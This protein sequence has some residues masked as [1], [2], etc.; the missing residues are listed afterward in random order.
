MMDMLHVNTTHVLEDL[1]PPP[2][3]IRYFGLF[4]MST[5]ILQHILFNEI[6]LKLK[7]SIP[8]CII[9]TRVKE[10]GGVKIK[11]FRSRS[12]E[13]DGNSEKCQNTHECGWM[14]Q[15]NSTYLQY[16][17]LT[18]Q[19]ENHHMYVILLLLRILI[20]SI[21]EFLICWVLW[22]KVT[23]TKISSGLID[24]GWLENWRNSYDTI[25]TIQCNCYHNVSHAN[26]N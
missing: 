16:F 17:S 22:S 6:K 13:C 1:P 12:A 14:V 18:F 11:Y 19:E 21:P 5:Y 4:N 10:E 2:F 26:K 9:N 23:V 3:S 24:P 15:D 8:R 25:V 7:K 20:L